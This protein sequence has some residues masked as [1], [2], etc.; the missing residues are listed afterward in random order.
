M[1]TVGKQNV[2]PKNIAGTGAPQIFESPPI[3]VKQ[4]VAEA[5]SVFRGLTAYDIPTPI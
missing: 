5:D 2:S 4:T 1:Y 3:G